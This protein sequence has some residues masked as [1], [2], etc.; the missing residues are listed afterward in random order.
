[1]VSSLRGRAGSLL[2]FGHAVKADVVAALP[3]APADAALGYAQ[4]TGIPFADVLWKIGMPPAF[5]PP[6][7]RGRSVR[8]P[9]QCVGNASSSSATAPMREAVALLRACGA[10]EVHLRVYVP[11]CSESCRY[12][13]A[14]RRTAE[15]AARDTVGYLSARQIHL[16]ADGL[17]TACMER[18]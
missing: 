4:Q 10:R 6:V 5:S 13:G 15:T 9:P 18:A 8:W 17:C 2:A 12:G 16:L 14:P 7:R 11:V 3:G 1:M